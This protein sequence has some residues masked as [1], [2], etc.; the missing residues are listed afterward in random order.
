MLYADHPLA[1]RSEISPSE[2]RDD[3]F[4]TNPAASGSTLRPG[5]P[6]ACHAAGFTPEIAQETSDG[7]R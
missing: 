2:P 1:K 4:V 5:V 6:A 3:P 7:T